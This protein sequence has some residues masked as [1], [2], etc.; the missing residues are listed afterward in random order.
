MLASMAAARDTKETKNLRLVSSGGPSHAGRQGGE[1]GPDDLESTPA[2]TDAGVGPR[3]ITRAQHGDPEA[4]QAIFSRYGK[5]VLAFIYHMLGDRTAAEELTQETFF[6]AYRG[7][8]RIQEGVKFSTWL[9]GIARNVAREAIRD[10]MRG[11]REVGR[12]DLAS[13]PMRD[14]KAGPEENV[15]SEELQR[16]IRRSLGSLPEDQRVVFVLKLLRRLPY[17]EISLITGASIGKLKTDLHRAR[18]QMR[19]SLLPYLAGRAP[20]M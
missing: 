11:V 19:Q 2:V 14:D 7:L 10:K 9:F 3:M 17:E 6:R 18:L 16:V 13:I 20:G 4:L 5:P 8:S 15:M 12:D 1:L